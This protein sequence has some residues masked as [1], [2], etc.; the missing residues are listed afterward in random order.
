MRGLIW[1][2]IVTFVSA[3]AI[4]W[5]FFADSTP[6]PE[7]APATA[8]GASEPQEQSR[9]IEPEPAIPAPEISTTEPT[10]SPPPL[11]VDSF[12][13]DAQPSL[14]EWE[15]VGDVG[16]HFDVLLMHSTGTSI[17]SGFPVA[18]DSV[19]VAKG[20]AGDHSL[21]ICFP[22][23]LLSMCGS[24]VGRAQVSG[25]RPDVA[26]AVHPNL[27]LSGWS[28]DLYAGDLPSCENPDLEVWAVVPGRRAALAALV[29]KRRIN[30]TPS[31]ATRE[32]ESAQVPVD[33]TKYW[34]YESVELNVTASRANMRRCGSTSCAVVSQVDRGTYPAAILDRVDGWSLVVVGDRA[35][36]LFDELFETAR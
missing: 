17:E 6:A 16:G 8:P 36:W 33:Q 7:T 5:L 23:V 28:A 4:F 25:P 32:H 9:A 10:T 24:F 20:W 29:G 18:A 14:D 26:E 2:L 11:I 31:S 19:I 12:P 13:A 34:P 3:A 35:G 27:G 30:V 15:R 21:G 22:D 1:L